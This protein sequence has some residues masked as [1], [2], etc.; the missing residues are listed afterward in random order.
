MTI[1]LDVQIVS[2]NTCVPEEVEFHHWANAVPVETDTSACLRIVD[3]TEAKSLNKKYR[4]IDK[5]T[6][7]LSFPAELPSQLDLS[8]LGDIV[9]CAP[10]VEGE[11]KQQN[12]TP[13]AHWAHLLVHGL[14]HLQG[15][16]HEDEKT[17]ELMES[18]EIQI[19]QK[20]KILNPYV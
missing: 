1:H 11:A 9:I 14:L 12:K 17:A 10:L 19:L 5:A 6:N 4:N 15:Y 16:D 18:K 7:V 20:L 2:K 8:F 3:E 13:S